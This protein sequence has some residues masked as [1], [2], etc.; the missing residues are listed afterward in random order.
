MSTKRGSGPTQQTEQLLCARVAGRCE[1]E[2]CDITLYEEIL[3]HKSIH[4][5]VVAHIVAASPDGPL[6]ESQ[7][8]YELSQCIDN[9][10]LLCPTH[11][12]L[13]DTHEED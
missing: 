6:G 4:N 8:S 13:I 5:S 1:F 7:R 2:G 9:L 11:H 10:M 3:S 12:T